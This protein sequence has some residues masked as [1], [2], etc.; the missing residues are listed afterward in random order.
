MTSY[1]STHDA[2]GFLYCASFIKALGQSVT[3]HILVSWDYQTTTPA[4]KLRALHRIRQHE[5]ILSYL[6][7]YLDANC[8]FHLSSSLGHL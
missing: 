7:I 3:Q 1:L 2:N 6:R 4:S 8:E 5:N